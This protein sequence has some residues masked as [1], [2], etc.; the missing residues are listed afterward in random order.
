MCGHS[1]C[2]EDK[3]GELLCWVC[4]GGG[5]GAAMGSAGAPLSS[6]FAFAAPPSPLHPHTGF[7]GF[8]PGHEP[9]PAHGA[10]WLFICAIHL[11]A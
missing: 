2:K 11:Q 10:L 5:C 3:K 1:V 4:V 7:G 8:V 6:G 9:F